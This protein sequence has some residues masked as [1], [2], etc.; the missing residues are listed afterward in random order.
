MGAT[1]D[2]EVASPREDQVR[3]AI[4][5]P[6]AVGRFAVTRASSLRSSHRPATSGRRLLSPGRT[7]TNCRAQLAFSGFCAGRPSSRRLRQLERC[8]RLCGVAHF[9]HGKKLPAAVRDRARIRYA[10]RIGYIV[11]VGQHDFDR[12]GQLQRQHHAWRRRNGRVAQGHGCSRSFQ[13]Q[14]VGTVQCARQCLGMDGGLLERQK[15]R[16]SGRRQGEDDRG[17]QPSRGARRF[18]QQFSAHASRGQARKGTCR[19]PRGC[20]RLSGCA[21][22]G[23]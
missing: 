22:F 12:T 16:Q 20:F 14:S 6:F 4:A 3:G 21:I 13:R 23:C 17:L 11:L 18:L 1:P 5:R 19:Q 15:C 9:R 8:A 2:E 10:R 7:E